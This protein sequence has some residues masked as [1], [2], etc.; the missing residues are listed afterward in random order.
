VEL[1]EILFILF[2]ILIPIFEGLRKS[3]Q[4]QGAE[5]EAEAAGEP[6]DRPMLE[7]RPSG[8]S[9]GEV[10]RPTTS[11]PL[12]PQRPEP[13]AGEASDMV[14][15]D[16]WE[17]LTGEKRARPVPEPMPPEEWDERPVLGEPESRPWWE[18]DP[19]AEAPE[20]DLEPVMEE[21]FEPAPWHEEPELEPESPPLPVETSSEIYTPLPRREPRPSPPRQRRPS[22]REIGAEP[23]PPVREPSALTRA[24]S[25]RAGLRQA[26][27]LREVLGRPKGLDS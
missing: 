26:V 19:E 22:L 5:R 1:F 20:P 18:E 7:P 23:A 13:A 9:G 16:L 11:A 4:R 25:T 6:E 24:L 15:D 12:P 27:I 3:R 8:R 14:P 2:F 10:R 21:R 17:I